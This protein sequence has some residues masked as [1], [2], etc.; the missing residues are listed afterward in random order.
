MPTYEYHCL[1][2][3]YSFELF[4]SISSYPYTDCPKCSNKVNRSISAGQGIIFKGSGF[5][6]TDYNKPSKTNKK[7]KTVSSEKPNQINKNK[8]KK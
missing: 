2:C 8:K 1:N 6:K 3:Q 4:Q 7:E 5:Y